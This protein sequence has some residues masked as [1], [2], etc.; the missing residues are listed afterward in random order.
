MISLRHKKQVEVLKGDQLHLEKSDIIAIMIAQF[1]ILM[2]LAL[3]AVVIFTL[4]MLFLMK[5][6]LRT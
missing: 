5:I 1:Q 2:P 3:I 4:L 6:W